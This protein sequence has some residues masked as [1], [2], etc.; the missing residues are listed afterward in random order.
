MNWWGINTFKDFVEV[1][2]WGFGIGAIVAAFVTYRLGR[3]QF[4]FQVMTSCVERFQQIMSQIK[5]GDKEARE[6]AIARY[7]DLCNEELFYFKN[8]FLPEEVMNEWLEGMLFY[9]PHYFRDEP[10][11][12]LNE[13]ATAK[14]IDS[15]NLLEDYP[16]ILKTFTFRVTMSNDL[17]K[18]NDRHQMIIG[19][20]NNLHNLELPKLSRHWD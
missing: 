5:S 20:K 8:G 2:A 18:E 9:L 3:N 13:D 17:S 10:G 11:K 4:N 12:N 1:L 6:V 16:R 7:V 14:F 19:L 15:N